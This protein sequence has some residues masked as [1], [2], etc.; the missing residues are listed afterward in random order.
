MNL[1]KLTAFIEGVITQRSFRQGFR[2]L[3]RRVFFLRVGEGVGLAVG[4]GLAGRSTARFVAA[5]RRTWWG[6]EW[7]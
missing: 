2:W 4:L 6:G 5:R 7:G 3:R 1:C